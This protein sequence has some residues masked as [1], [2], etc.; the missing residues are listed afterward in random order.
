MVYSFRRI[1]FT[2]VGKA[3]GQSRRPA[4]HIASAFRK[5]RKQEVGQAMKPQR[6]LPVT[7]FLQISPTS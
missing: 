1:E 4:C 7:H 2:I 6:Q 5:Q 3:W